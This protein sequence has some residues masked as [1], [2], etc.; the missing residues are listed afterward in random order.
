MSYEALATAIDQLDP[1]GSIRAENICS[2][3]DIL[4]TATERRAF[5]GYDISKDGGP[6]LRTP[7]ELWLQRIIKVNRLEDKIA[8]LQVLAT[9]NDKVDQLNR[10]FDGI[11]STCDAV[12]KNTK[13]PLL[14]NMVRQ[15]GNKLNN[16][17]TKTNSDNGDHS[18]VEGF[19]LDFLPRLTLTKGGINKKLN[20][21]DLLVSI[22]MDRDQGHI[23]LFLSEDDLLRN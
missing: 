19:K 17:T 10:Q 22:L 16:R 21:L 5:S 4:P 18:S 15:I 12:T 8:V 13:L 20:A 23:L 1:T 6:L 3:N 14:L 9:F 2:L 11:I 7:A